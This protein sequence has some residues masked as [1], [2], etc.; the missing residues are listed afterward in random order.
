MPPR[1]WRGNSEILVRLPRPSSVT[2]RTVASRR[3][4][5]MPATSS[6]PLRD[7]PF[8]PWAVRPTT[9][10]WLSSKRM[11]R[12]PRARSMTSAVPSERATSMMASPSFT[13]AA[14]IPPARGLENSESSVRFTTPFRD[15]KTR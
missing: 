7:I 3:M 11:A 1:F 4:R 14:M 5:S 8:T 15:R 6:S 9:L 10:I 13:P 12:P 2:V